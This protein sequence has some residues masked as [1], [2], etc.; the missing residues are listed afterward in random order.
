MSAKTLRGDPPPRR[1]VIL[2]ARRERVSIKRFGSRESGTGPPGAESAPQSIGR[3]LGNPL[4][5][6]RQ[7]AQRVALLGAVV[8]PIVNLDDA[9]QL[10]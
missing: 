5:Q 8:V 2:S 10:N 1:A 6:R 4:D 7:L 9:G 3:P